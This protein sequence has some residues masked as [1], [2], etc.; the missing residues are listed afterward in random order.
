[1]CLKVWTQDCGAAQSYKRLQ[2][3]R[4]KISCASGSPF[5]GIG[6]APDVSI[7]RRIADIA[8][9]RDAVMS[10]AIELATE[11]R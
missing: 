10:R 7:E 8:A 6:S 4:S 11:M 5:E 2:G 9:N 3:D 1:L